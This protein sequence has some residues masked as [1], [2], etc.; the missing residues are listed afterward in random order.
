MKNSLDIRF[1]TW[2]AFVTLYIDDSAGTIMIIKYGRFF[3]IESGVVDNPFYGVML[4][5]LRGFQHHTILNLL[6]RTEIG[7][8]SKPM[9]IFL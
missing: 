5:G 7:R 9:P 4:D 6:V 1:S 2:H 8:R 3:I